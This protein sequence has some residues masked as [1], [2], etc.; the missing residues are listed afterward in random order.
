MQVLVPD[1][2]EEVL[3][4]IASSHSSAVLQLCALLTAVKLSSMPQCEVSTLGKEAV[5]HTTVLYSSCS[6][7]PLVDQS[8]LFGESAHCR[9]WCS[10]DWT[11]GSPSANWRE[12]WDSQLW[13]TGSSGSCIRSATYTDEEASYKL[14]IWAVTF[15]EKKEVLQQ[16]L[17]SQEV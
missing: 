14:Q 17:G 8:Y 12:I 5:L 11:A 9:Y 2:A 15:T 1:L 13:V 10:A 4:S 6:P 7:M 3:S 16:V